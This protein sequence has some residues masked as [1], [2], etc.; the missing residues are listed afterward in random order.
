MGLKNFGFIA[1][2]FVVSMRNKFLNEVYK[3]NEDL[4]DPIDIDKVMNDDWIIKR[5]LIAS[6][7]REDEAIERMSTALK[8][9]KERD[10]HHVKENLFPREFFET[11]ALFIYEPDRTGVPSL[12]MRLKFVKKTP[13]LIEH[14]KDFCMYQIFKIDRDTN[15]RGWMLVFD[16]SDCGYQIYQ[17]IDLLHYFITNMHTYFPAGMDYVLV[18]DLPW[19]LSSFWSLVRMW[20]PEKRREMV[21][22]C[23]KANLTDFFEPE[24]LPPVL[25]GTCARKYKSCP[26]N[27]ATAYD[28]GIEMGLEKARCDEILQEW[29]PLL[30]AAKA[31][32]E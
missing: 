23:S 15:G 27:C 26:E 7:K 6:Y 5:F 28:L 29:L 4:Y 31:E 22:F 13:E 1:D 20:I 25:G 12:I 19:Y 8:Y 3:G 21:Q 16:F 2:E 17:H 24:N 18:V 30:E 14:M 9:Y 10:V 32:D 11:G